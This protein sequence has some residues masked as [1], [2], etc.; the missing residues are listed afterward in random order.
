MRFRSIFRVSR[1][2]SRGDKS[3]LWP[4]ARHALFPQ[5]AGDLLDLPPM[6]GREGIDIEILSVVIVLAAVPEQRA[7][8]AGLVFVKN[9][10]PL[11]SGLDDIRLETLAD[12]HDALR[13]C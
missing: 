2:P 9:E 5:V 4:S 10:I 6:F 7:A 12:E 3:T 13:Y 8:Y 1:N 11:F